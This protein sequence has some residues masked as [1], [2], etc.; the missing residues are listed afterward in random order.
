[1]ANFGIPSLGDIKKAVQTVQQSA[2]TVQQ[3]AL[4]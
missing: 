3:S 1:M 4:Y 2:Q